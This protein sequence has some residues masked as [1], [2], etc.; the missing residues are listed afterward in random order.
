[1]AIDSNTRIQF[2]KCVR[3]C[4]DAMYRVAF[5]L[6][7]NET[8]ATELVQ[9][10]YFHAWKSL[11]SLK[12]TE[13]VKGWMFAILRNQYTKLLQKEKR[14][15]STAE[16]IEVES[17]EKAQK[18]FEDKDMIQFALSKLDDQ[19]RLPLLLVSMEELSVDEASEVLQIPRGTVLSRLHRGR[20]KMKEILSQTT[21]KSH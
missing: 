7:G 10:T 16:M 12:E 18:H 1:M 6:L 19:H 21:T 5:R 13:K 14:S 20:Q 3:E 17:T 4:A 11:A 8:L 15:V 2:E 9:E